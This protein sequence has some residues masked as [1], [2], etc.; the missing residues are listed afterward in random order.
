MYLLTLYIEVMSPNFPKPSAIK[1]QSPTYFIAV[2][3]I[4]FPYLYTAN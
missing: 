4:I 3:N 1:Q 2:G